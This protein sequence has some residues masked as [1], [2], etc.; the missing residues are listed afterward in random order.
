M[1]RSMLDAVDFVVVDVLQAI[2]SLTM[3]LLF[4][5]VCPKF[6]KDC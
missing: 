4:A 3:L 5:S 6:S 2:V 1:M